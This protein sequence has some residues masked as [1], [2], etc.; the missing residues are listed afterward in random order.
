VKSAT[1][2][3]LEISQVAAKRFLGL[4]YVSVSAHWRHIQE[5]PVLFHAERLAECDRLKL[6]AAQA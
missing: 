5:S 2:N 3:C 4:P 6:A 1:F